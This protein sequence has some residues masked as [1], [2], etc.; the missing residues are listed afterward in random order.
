MEIYFLALVQGWTGL[1]PP[2]PKLTPIN[3][4]KALSTFS[5]KFICDSSR[6][7]QLQQLNN[8]QVNMTKPQVVLV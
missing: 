2:G 3:Q 5:I 1:T 7:I 8:P 6:G 4:F